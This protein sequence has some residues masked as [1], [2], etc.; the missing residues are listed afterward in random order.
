M[1]LGADG[2]LNGVLIISEFMANR[3]FDGNRIA[4]FL[5]ANFYTTLGCVMILCALFNMHC[6]SCC[7]CTCAECDGVPEPY[8]LLA[9]A[10][11][12]KPLC[13]FKAKTCR[14]LPPPQR[15]DREDSWD[16]E[17]VDARI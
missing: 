13:K 6:K 7:T 10:C 12:A 11:D 16:D 2:N 9:Y 15:G 4:G 14:G 1:Y 17:E 8:P 5:F 3:N